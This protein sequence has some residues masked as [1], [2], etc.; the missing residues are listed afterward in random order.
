MSDEMIYE[1]LTAEEFALGSGYSY[2]DVPIVEDESASYVFA[3]GHIDPETY[4]AVVNDYDREMGGYDD[5]DLAYA[6]KD[7]QH[8]WAV[9]TSPP[10]GPEGWYISW[11]DE[12]QENADRFP[13]TVVSR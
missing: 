2:R 5:P 3:H 1:P 10:D 11:A 4:A 8:V 6:A 12:H 9:V 7:V 13:L